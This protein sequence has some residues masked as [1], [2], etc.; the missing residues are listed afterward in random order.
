MFLFIII[1]FSPQ[2]LKKF[3]CNGKTILCSDVSAENTNI[4]GHFQKFS[5]TDKITIS[6]ISTWELL[7]LAKCHPRETIQ[8]EKCMVAL[9]NSFNES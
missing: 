5:E 6:D 1:I 8:K 9:I 2:D 4:L 7:V 3:S